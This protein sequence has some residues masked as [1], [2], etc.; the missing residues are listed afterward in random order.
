MK[1]NI[2]GTGY[3]MASNCYNTCFTIEKNQKHFL[4]DSGGGNTLLNNLNK[5]KI[6]A[7]NI[8]AVFIS[9][10][11]IDHILGVLWLIRYI[12]P[13][14]Y[15]KHIVEPIT[16]Y[17]NKKVISC[18][19]ILIENLMPPDFLDLIDN[20]IILKT[21]NNNDKY[22][23]LGNEVV[24]FDTYAKKDLQYGFS[25][26]FD[27]DKKFTFI[28]DEYCKNHTKKYINNSTWLFADAYMCGEE[29]EKYNPMR[30]H[31]HSSVKYISTIANELNVKNLI[32]SHT[33]DNNLKV[34]KSTFS[35]DS[36]KYFF[37]N[38]FIP[39]DLETI[40]M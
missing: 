27:E 23:I 36:K 29:A 33:V 35:E 16:L 11:H 28:G 21:V 10:T 20:K 8:N 18:L 12:L 34:R 39:D 37:G 14:Y 1:I 9:H 15:K 6:P 13:K 24:F 38:I 22:M 32:L 25:M 31:C 17:G 40:L 2:L 5:M 26:K 7:E 30:R 19:R 3:G 4:I